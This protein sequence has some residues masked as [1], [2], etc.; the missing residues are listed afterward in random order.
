[1]TGTEKNEL[2]CETS[3]KQEDSDSLY[4]IDGDTPTISFN[5]HPHIQN[6]HNLALAQ[7]QIRKQTTEES[8]V[9]VFNINQ[10]STSHY[11]I[12][13]T[14]QHDVSSMTCGHLRDDQSAVIDFNNVF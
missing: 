9:E 3:N 5:Q 10:H 12:A 1:M 11:G 2:V 7:E 13:T 8:E 14:T 4:D 6:S